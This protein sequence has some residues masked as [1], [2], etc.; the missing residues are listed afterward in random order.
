MRSGK[1]EEE[2]VR[3]VLL[4]LAHAAGSPRVEGEDEEVG[5]ELGL[6]GALC[7]RSRKSSSSASELRSRGLKKS[8]THASPASA[9]MAHRSR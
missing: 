6:V 8:V 3:Q 7:N 9:G 2:R 4:A 5:D 1:E